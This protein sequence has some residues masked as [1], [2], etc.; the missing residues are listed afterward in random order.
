ML[1]RHLTCTMNSRLPPGGVLTKRHN[2][3]RYSVSKD[4]STSQ[5]QAM[6]SSYSESMHRRNTMQLKL[7]E[8]QRACP[9]SQ[10]AE[11]QGRKGPRRT[12]RRGDATSFSP[13]QVPPNASLTSMVWNREDALLIAPSRLRPNRTRRRSAWRRRS[14]DRH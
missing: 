1:L 14:S 5:A 11:R 13:L 7:A 10:S 4:G 8:R 3:L 2:A 9:P 12:Q 6:M